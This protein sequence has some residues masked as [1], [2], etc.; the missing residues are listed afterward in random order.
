MCC[1]Q[2]APAGILGAWS[3]IC[4]LTRQMFSHSNSFQWA[5][6]SW[7]QCARAHLGSTVNR[8][9]MVVTNPKTTSHFGVD[10][11]HRAKENRTHR[12]HWPAA[13]S[14]DFLRVR[15]GCASVKPSVC[16]VIP[17]LGR[18]R[19]E[20]GRRTSYEARPACPAFDTYSAN[21]R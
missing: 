1:F 2:N 18:M 13:S 9:L 20:C 19:L 10:A 14:L 11:S 17:G 4:L 16:F 5:I 8:F 3:L 15:C 12:T 6:S 21:T 7:H